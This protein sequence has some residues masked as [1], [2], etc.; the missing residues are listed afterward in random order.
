[1]IDGPCLVSGASMI[2]DQIFDDY[3]PVNPKTWAAKETPAV[4]ILDTKSQARSK[5]EFIVDSLLYSPEREKICT[6]WSSVRN[7]RIQKE[8]NA[9]VQ[10][11]VNTNCVPIDL[12]HLQMIATNTSSL[13]PLEILEKNQ[14]LVDYYVG[15]VMNMY[16]NVQKHL[17]EKVCI[18]A[19]TLGLLYKMQQG[20]IID[21]I[22]LI[23]IDD[24]LVRHLPLMNDLPKFGIDKKKF[25]K[26]EKLI[27]QLFN[28][29]DINLRDVSCRI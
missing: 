16:E 17:E 22:V 7:K 24:F 20:K 9:Y 21:G 6:Q 18:E 26:G 19:I 23:P 27:N 2:F 14:G 8:K 11:C 15:L 5:A 4:K 3:N 29:R 28:K 10:S 12:I 13:P 1:M 25:T